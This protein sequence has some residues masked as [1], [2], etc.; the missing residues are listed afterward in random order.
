MKAKELK[1]KSVTELSELE[2]TIRSELFQTRLQNFTNQLDNTST[3]P[4]RRR[5]L[6]RVATE[7]RS[8]EL[9][10]LTKSIEAAMAGET[11]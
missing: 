9:D 11:K 8:R 5:D 2:T 6:A 4:K 10:S 7:L 3:I 1:D